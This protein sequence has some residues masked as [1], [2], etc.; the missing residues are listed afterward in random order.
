MKREERNQISRQQEIR[1]SE[2]Q[3]TADT[4]ER[5]EGICG[6]GLRIKLNQCDLCGG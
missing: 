1:L 4:G 6:K 5:S 2:D 3:T